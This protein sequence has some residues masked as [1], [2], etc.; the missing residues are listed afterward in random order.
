MISKTK[1]TISNL[2]SL[3]KRHTLIQVALEDLKRDNVRL[4]LVINRPPGVYTDETDELC[5]ID[6]SLHQ[7]AIIAQLEAELLALDE[8]C[9][10]LTKQLGEAE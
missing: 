3:S 8:E 10:R 6:I 7:S 2:F 1:D 5:K 9:D 4:N